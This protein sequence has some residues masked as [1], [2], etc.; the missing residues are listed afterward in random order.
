M[1]LFIIAIQ[2]LLLINFNLCT[3]SIIIIINATTTQ[4]DI[5]YF[6]QI[7]YPTKISKFP[8]L[9]NYIALLNG[10][11]SVTRDILWGRK[12]ISGAFKQLQVTQ[13]KPTC[14]FH[15]AIHAKSCVVAG[16]FLRWNSEPVSSDHF[17]SSWLKEVHGDR[18][19][20]YKN[21]GTWAGLVMQLSD[22]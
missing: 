5:I 8:P 12:E 17:L 11:D 19:A 6:I 9:S 2:N 1:T 10:L 21:L 22:M 13:K 16:S 18:N 14:N 7:F 4:I 20:T 15:G 3:F